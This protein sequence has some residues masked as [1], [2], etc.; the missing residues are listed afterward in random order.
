MNVVKQTTTTGEVFLTHSSDG[1]WFCEVGGHVLKRTTEPFLFQQD[2][3]KLQIFEEEDVIVAV[4][5]EEQFR[6]QLVKLMR[7]A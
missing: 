4:E 6:S 5:T 7:H 3:S 1:T 2:V